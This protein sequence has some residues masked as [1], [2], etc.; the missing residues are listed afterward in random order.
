MIFGFVASIA[1]SAV[2]PPILS[3]VEKLLDGELA[4]M[5]FTDPPYNVNYVNSEKDR[6][7]GKNRPIL[8]D[9]LGEDFGALLYDA[10]VNLLTLTKGAVYI[11]MYSSELDRL[12][13]A[14]REAGGKWSTFVIWAKNNLHARPL[15]LPAPI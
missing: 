8:N 7:K 15:R 2:T 13:K 3:D 6:K 1:C 5:A 14:F 9:A 12:Q 4:D 10:C 11:C